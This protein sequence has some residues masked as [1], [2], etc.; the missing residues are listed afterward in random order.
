MAE[1]SALP[2][3]API[4]GPL[5]AITERRGLGYLR[6]AAWADSAPVVRA[7]LADALG[8]AAPAS[9]R[10]AAVSPSGNVIAAPAP[11]AWLVI[12]ADRR[13]VDLAA[14]LGAR[15]GPAD[16]AISEQDDGLVALR[17]AGPKARD[18]LAKGSRIDLHPDAFPPGTVAQS[19]MHR[20]GALLHRAGEDVYDVYVARSY[21]RSLCDALV[22]AAR[23]FHA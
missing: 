19:P 17:L 10:L 8:A 20:I 3:P 15:L 2:T 22:D 18:V 14:D 11:D 1:R 21:A 23:E 4:N 12:L 7:A 6:V 13:G 5:I 16:A 9:A